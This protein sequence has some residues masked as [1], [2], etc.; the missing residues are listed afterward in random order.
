MFV[1][2]CLFFLFRVAWWPS[3]G[4]ELSSWFSIC[5]VLLYTVFVFLSRLVSRVRK[6]NFNCIG[7]C[8]LSF[9]L[10][11]K[12]DYLRSL[13]ETNGNVHSMEGSVGVEWSQMLGVDNGVLCH[14]FR[15]IHD[16]FKKIPRKSFHSSDASLN[17]YH[18]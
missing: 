17:F 1:S 9:H 16:R 11:R 18:G 4:N 3:S 7:S 6:W 2:D 12:I 8:S 15:R 14:S 13:N 10:L 5:A